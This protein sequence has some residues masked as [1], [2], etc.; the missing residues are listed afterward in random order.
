LIPYWA[1][2]LGKARLEARQISRRGGALNCTLDGERVTI[3]GRASLYL[4]GTI[5]I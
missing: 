5:S 4:T 1:E 2:R 3:A